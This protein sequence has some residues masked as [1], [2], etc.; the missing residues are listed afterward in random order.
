MRCCCHIHHNIDGLD[1]LVIDDACLEFCVDS[2]GCNTSSGYM[3][4][5]LEVF[6]S[7]VAHGLST[8][9]LHATGKNRGQEQIQIAT[10]GGRSRYNLICVGFM[11]SINERSC[12]HGT[13]LSGL[14]AAKGGP[15]GTLMTLG[16]VRQCRLVCIPQV[17]VAMVDPCAR[18]L[19]LD[20][21]RGSGWL[22]RANSSHMW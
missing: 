5:S 16:S 6:K 8:C 12:V 17:Q 15:A 20:N 19:C 1:E 3:R 10:R 13:C 18:V 7:F 2:D 9:H 14:I 4:L 21:R 22:E 11:C